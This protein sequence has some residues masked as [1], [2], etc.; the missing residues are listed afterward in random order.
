MYQ[1]VGWIVNTVQWLLALILMVD[2]HTPQT[3]K[4]RDCG[5]GSAHAFR[6]R[7]PGPIVP[8]IL[9]KIFSSFC[10]ALSVTVPRFVTVQ[11]DYI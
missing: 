5:L 4:A 1:E 11:W 8:G 3:V 7:L 2:F 6:A 10:L 9:V